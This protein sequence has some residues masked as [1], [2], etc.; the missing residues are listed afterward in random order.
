VQE[1]LSKNETFK[2]FGKKVLSGTPQ[3]I[4]GI[5]IEVTESSIPRLKKTKSVLDLFNNIKNAIMTA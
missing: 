5:V 1:T 3:P 2:L 4:N